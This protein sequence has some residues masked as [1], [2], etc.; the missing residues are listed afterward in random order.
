[1]SIKNA[2]LNKKCRSSFLACIKLDRSPGRCLIF[3]LICLFLEYCLRGFSTDEFSQISWWLAITGLSMIAESDI[4]RNDK[5]IKEGS[6][7]YAVFVTLKLIALTQIAVLSFELSEI[8]QSATFDL[9]APVFALTSLRLTF[10]II[11]VFHSSYECP[12]YAS[13]TLLIQFW[14]QGNSIQ[15]VELALQLLPAAIYIYPAALSSHPFQR[16]IHEKED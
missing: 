13:A 4:Q 12:I 7:S 2:F 14:Q 16:Y 10:W 11:C 1:M 8:F 5:L 6:P 15:S 3:T 9:S